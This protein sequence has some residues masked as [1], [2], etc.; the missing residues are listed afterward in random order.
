MEA[1]LLGYVCATVCFGFAASLGAMYAVRFVA[2]SFA[3]AL[4][5]ATS[6]LI[7][8]SYCGEVRVAQKLEFLLD[9]VRR[10]AGRHHAEP[11]HRLAP[12]RDRRPHLPRRR[13]AAGRTTPRIARRRVDPQPWKQHFAANPGRSALHTLAA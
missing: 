10:E 9:R 13:A 12:A 8:K 1:G 11:H 3:A 4:V 2:S 5:P 7:A 6:A